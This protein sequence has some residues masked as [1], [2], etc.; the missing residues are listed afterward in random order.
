[1]GELSLIPNPFNQ[2]LFQ[3]V[4]LGTAPPAAGA[5]FNYLVPVNQRTKFAMVSYTFE[6]DVNAAHRYHRLVHVRGASTVRIGSD[7]LG[8]EAS[9]IQHVTY[10]PHGVQTGAVNAKYPVLP[11]LDSPAF[12]EGD[13]IGSDIE[14]IQV[15]DQITDVHIILHLQIFPQ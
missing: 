15:G 6:T 11:M 12:L 7:Q 3:V 8:V 9:Q 2:G 10:F 5:N 14:D 1:M 13:Y 4:I